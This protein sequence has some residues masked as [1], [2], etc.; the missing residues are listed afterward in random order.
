MDN[1]E[2]SVWWVIG[3]REYDHWVD[4]SAKRM[5]FSQECPNPQHAAQAR[6]DDGIDG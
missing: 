6:I 2:C 3:G 5:T 4:G 1:C